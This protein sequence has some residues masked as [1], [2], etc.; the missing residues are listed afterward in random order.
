MLSLSKHEV[1]LTHC[2]FWSFK[3]C[4]RPE[5]ASAAASAFA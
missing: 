5:A 1:K 3:G 4:R 2:Q